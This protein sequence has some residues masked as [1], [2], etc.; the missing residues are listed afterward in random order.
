MAKKQKYNILMN[1]GTKQEVEGEVVNGVWGIDKRVEVT[2][3]QTM[4]DGS[5]RTLSSTS[6]IVTHITTGA[7]LPTARFR[8]LKS[9]KLLLS[10]P[11]FFF[12]ELNEEAVRNMADAIGRFWNQRGWRD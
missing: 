7:L 9:A 6:Y 1:D 12:D 5:T 3:E 11:E 8:T 2:G 10:E 4:K